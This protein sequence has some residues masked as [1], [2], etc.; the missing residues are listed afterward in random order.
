MASI[1]RDTGYTLS[2]LVE[3]IRIGRIALP[4]HAFLPDLED[5][6]ARFGE[7]VIRHFAKPS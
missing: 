5:G 7:T 3:D 6:L 2:H 1:Y 4:A